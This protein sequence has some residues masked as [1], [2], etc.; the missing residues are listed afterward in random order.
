M[1]LC[2]RGATRDPSA[3]GRGGLPIRPSMWTLA[4]TK[5]LTCVEHALQLVRWTTRRLP[6][7][8]KVHSW[9]EQWHQQPSTT[10]KRVVHAITH[11]ASGP[12]TMNN[13]SPTCTQ[14]ALWPLTPLLH[15]PGTEEV[16]KP[17]GEGEPH[18]TIPTTYR[19][20][21]LRKMR[22]GKQMRR[23]MRNGEKM[24]RKMP[25][26]MSEK[27][28]WRKMRQ[29]SGL[30]KDATKMRPVLW[31]WVVPAVCEPLQSDPGADGLPGAP[32]SAALFYL[33]GHILFNPWRY[34]FAP[35]L[36]TGELGGLAHHKSKR[37]HHV[38]SLESWSRVLPY[39]ALLGKVRC[40]LEGKDSTKPFL[41]HLV[42]NDTLELSEAGNFSVLWDHGQPFFSPRLRIGLVNQKKKD[43]CAILDTRESGMA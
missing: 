15:I 40:Q 29:S 37:R 23:K 27:K 36:T 38:Q 17:K 11:H 12:P 24:R 31:V 32:M 26:K 28:G 1:I 8:L 3:T 5:S 33:F 25:R 30:S 42:H 22:A 21:M 14:Q 7:W 18:K 43:K 4:P 41:K 35:P 20:P 10:S 16:H 39:F 9:R 19:I 2:G 34:L 6:R 13:T